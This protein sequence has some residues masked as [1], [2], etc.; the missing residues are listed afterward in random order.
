MKI[1]Y[2][3]VLAKLELGTSRRGYFPWKQSADLFCF[4]TA[5][6]RSVAVDPKMN[7]WQFSDQFIFLFPRLKWFSRL[8]EVQAI[9]WYHFSGY[10]NLKKKIVMYFLPILGDAICRVFSC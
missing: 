6:L 8:K 5:E 1:L 2:E 9:E 7:E 3:E 10:M 4:L